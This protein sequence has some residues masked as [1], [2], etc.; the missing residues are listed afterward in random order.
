MRNVR[1]GD[2]VVVVR[3]MMMDKVPPLAPRLRPS[4]SKMMVG[5]ELKAETATEM[6]VTLSQSIAALDI[7]LGVNLG[8]RGM[9]A[10]GC[11]PRST[12]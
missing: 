4:Q 1:A 7:F 2:V 5:E 10:G 8:E 6:E 9:E 3:R 11:G 12:I